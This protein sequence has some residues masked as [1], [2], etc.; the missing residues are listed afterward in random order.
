MEIKTVTMHIGDHGVLYNTKEEA[1]ASFKARKMLE[2]TVEIMSGIGLYLSEDEIEEIS[3][4]I[5]KNRDDLIKI[6][7]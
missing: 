5:V 6:L 7:K 1:E 4:H 2:N 3:E